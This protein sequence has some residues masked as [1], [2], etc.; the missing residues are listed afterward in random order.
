MAAGINEKLVRRHPHVF[1]ETVAGDAGAVVTAGD[2]GAVVTAGDVAAVVRNWDEIK[3]Q[4]RAEKLAAAP[5]ASDD[6]P[7]PFAGVAAA[8]PA[9]AYAAK[10]QRRARG[11]GH[12]YDAELEVRLHAGLEAA[13]AV[14]GGAEPT[15]EQLGDALFAVV[16]LSRSSG[17]DPE[18]ALR[19]AANRFRTAVEAAGPEGPPPA[20]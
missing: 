12:E 5:G 17:A 20:R 14:L 11:A 9:L 4:E 15:A 16:A 13:R 8:L 2:A 18:E 1:G 6:R 7:G 19:E 10:L 3:R